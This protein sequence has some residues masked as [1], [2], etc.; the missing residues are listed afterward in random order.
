MDDREKLLEDEPTDAE[1][2]ELAAELES[3]WRALLASDLFVPAV[4]V[5][6]LAL[7]LWLSLRVS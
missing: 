5:V 4:T 7:T 1:V 6:G 2:G 3:T